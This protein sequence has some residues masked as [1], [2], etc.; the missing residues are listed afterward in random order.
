MEGSSSLLYRFRV[1]L[2]LVL[3]RLLRDLFTRYALFDGRYDC[4]R[5]VVNLLVDVVSGRNRS[6]VYGWEALKKFFHIGVFPVLFE[7]S[8]TPLRAVANNYFD[9]EVV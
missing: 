4:F 2:V 7:G 6:E 1:F 5:E 3:L 9:W 8:F